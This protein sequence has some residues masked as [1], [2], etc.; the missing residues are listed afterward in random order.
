[1]SQLPLYQQIKR[2]II[3]QIESGAWSVGQ[4]IT[5]ELELTEQFNVSRMTV[6]KAIRDLVSEGRLQRTP[7]LGTF[8][9]QVQ[10]KAESPLVDIRNIA[11]EVAERG[12]TYSNKVVAQSQINADDATATKLGVMRGS[13]VFF[14]EIIHYADDMPIQLELRWVNPQYAKDYLKQDF[15]EQNATQYLFEACP[16]SAI[17]HSVEAVTIDAAKT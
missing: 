8:V 4:R 14:S 3:N 13:P 7:R 1:M 17:E 2:Y 5:T 6:N 11:I 16:L 10:D 15:A 12:K 9:C